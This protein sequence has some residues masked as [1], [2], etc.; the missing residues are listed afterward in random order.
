LK[1]K[2]REFQQVFPVSLIDFLG[3]RIPGSPL[4][5]R[6]AVLLNLVTW[7]HILMSNIKASKRGDNA[8]S[9]G[10]RDFLPTMKE[11]LPK[12]TNSFYA[13]KD[14]MPSLPSDL[15]IILILLGT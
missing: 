4:K 1:C 15:E 3:A 13:K 11:N 12:L 6:P 5:S 9:G 8:M 14:G 2:N 10:M 7:G